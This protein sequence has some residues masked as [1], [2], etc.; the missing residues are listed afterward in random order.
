M[1]VVERPQFLE[2]SLFFLVEMRALS[3]AKNS[4]KNSIINNN[5]VILRKH[6]YSN[7]LKILQPKLENFQIKKSY[8]FQ[9]SAQNMDFGYSLDSPR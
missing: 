1:I 7:T 4:C 5:P 2:V 6:A 9:I 8:I 3:R